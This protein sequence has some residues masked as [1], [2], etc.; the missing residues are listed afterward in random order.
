MY[1]Y[2]YIEWKITNF[3][4]SNFFITFKYN[5][6]ILNNLQ[7]LDKFVKLF[8]KLAIFKSNSISLFLNNPQILFNYQF[9]G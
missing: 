1:M 9:I 8:I 3:I 6:R 2:M 4:L 5:A 7:L